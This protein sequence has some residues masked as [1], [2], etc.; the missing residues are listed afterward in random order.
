MAFIR[1]SFVISVTLLSVFFTNAQTVSYPLQSSQLLKSTAEDAAML[2]QKAVA[3]SQFTTSIYSGIPQTGVIFIYDST[4]TNNQ[5]C[6]VESDGINFIKFYA[7]QDNGL[8]FGFYQY[9]QQLGFRFYQPGTIWEII[10]SLSSAYKKTDSVYT[11]NFKY[12]SW[13][14]SGG[15]SR[16]A[17]DNSNSYGWDT[18]Y[19]E[20]GHNWAL[21]QR[22]NGMM[23]QYRFA[24]HRSDVIA[25][26]SLAT[27][28]NNP[29]YVASYDSSRQVNS[30]SVPDVNSTAAMQ[31]WSSTIEQK[32]QAYKNTIFGNTNLYVNLYR[33][34]NYSNYNIGIEVP[35]GALWGNTKDN[36][37]C[38]NAGYQKESDQNLTLANY[39]AQ[40]IGDKYSD[41]HFQ[42]YAYSTHADIPSANIPI[43]QKLDIQ[44]IPTVYQSLTSTNGLR[45][46]WFSRTKNISEYNYLNL[47]DWSGET[48]EFYLDEFKTTVQIAKENNSQGLIWEASPAKFASLPYLL[49]ANKSLKDDKTIDN[50]LIEFC[51]NMFADAGKIIYKLL[52]LWTDRTNLAGGVSNRYKMPLYFQMVSD[53]ESKITQESEVVKARLRELK[54]YLHYMSLYYEW[55]GN[56]RRHDA[57]TSSAAA[58]CIYLAKINK[59]QLVN[60]YYLIINITAKNANNSNFYGQYNYANGTAYQNGALPLITAAE[61]EN[62]FK[63]DVAKFSNNINKYKFEQEAVIPNNYDAAGL[64]P[65]KKITVKLNY[66]N[67]MDYY[68]SSEFFI[69]APAAGNFTIN[70]KPTFDMPDKGYINITVEATDKVL[71]II[72]DFSMDKNAKAG[73]LKISLPSAGNYK[74]T[75]SSKYKSR[76]ELDILTNKNIFYKSG[77]FF[78][79]ATE[80]YTNNTGMPAYFYIPT[81]INKIYF[82][83]GN[84]NPAGA[85]FASAEKINNA[86][87]I[88]DNTGNTLTARFVTPNDSALFY[89]EIP[90]SAIGKF[91]R[92]TKKPNFD[93]VFSNISNFLWYAQPKPLPCSNADFTISAVNKNGNCI[94][95]LKAVAAAGQFEW[96]VT[97][98]GRTYTYSNQRIIELPDYSSPNAIVTLTNGINCSTTKKLKD[99]DKFLKAKQACASGGALPDAAI[100]PAIHPNPS[101]GNF[102]C[103]QNGVE[104]TANQVIILNAQGAHVAV[105]NNIKQFNISNVSAGT[106]WYKII[107]NGE[108]F[109]GKLLKL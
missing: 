53:A 39:T 42:L 23:G 94:T 47:T 4:I 59:L 38:T 21:Y 66:T 87:A 104:L 6:R 64:I 105:F 46:R 40:K 98:L 70:Y 10:P 2:L 73:S 85:G 11:V 109:S 22:R 91:C 45:K 32:Y 29:C 55:A 17:M 36:Q 16:W 65:Q 25:G 108:A 41:L 83:L 7:S 28:Q 9:L 82:S 51:D 44:L 8:C 24:G 54:A 95:Q 5:A 57:K 97:D 77:A 103:M 13:F 74:M 107:V 81:G 78:G 26:N 61:I 100:V 72:E 96:E 93:L 35:D 63:N 99:D 80:V 50:T 20:N 49:A 71:D 86:F 1:N 37:G 79:K 12:N 102:R 75:V 27:W 56:Q 89:I 33:N 30:R 92:F 48:P 84:S 19:G 88:Q 31:L 68:N 76:V 3:A 14:I 106:Y 15:H 90:T 101:T 58:L 52:Q 69:K 67:G 18:Y 34:F 43:H 60:S 62:D